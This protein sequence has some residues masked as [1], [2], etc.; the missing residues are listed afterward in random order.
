MKI[1]GVIFDADGPLYYRDNSVDKLRRALLK[2]FGYSG[3]Y[4]KFQESYEKEKWAA[5]VKKI[6]TDTLFKRILHSIG[7]RLD[8]KNLKS[9]I[10]EFFLAH[11]K[12]KAAE[13]ALDVLSELKARG[14]KVCVLT[15]TFFSE[16]EK[17]KWFKSIHLGK[18]LH[19][20]VCSCDIGKLKNSKEA[21]EECLKRLEL[22]PHEVVFVGHKQYEMD[23]AK[24]V[25]IISIAIA[26]ISDANVR[27]DYTID[28]ITQLP[29]LIPNIK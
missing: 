1:R 12:I 18:Y 2:K 19:A 4:K 29:I 6:S 25:C 13:G 26:P 9:F 22:K 27:S 28:S 8:A 14:I 24:K 21:Y 20:I 16:S 3:N 7:M 15:D 5:Y 23:A 10:K 17:W 11:R